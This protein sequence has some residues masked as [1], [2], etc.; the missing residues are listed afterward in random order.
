[1]SARNRILSR[2]RSTLASRTPVPHPG[3]FSGSPPIALRTAVAAFSEAFEKAGGEVVRV[4]DDDAA[5]SWLS[6]TGAHF[7]TATAG[8]GVPENLRPALPS[9]D[10]HHADLGVSMARYAVA[11]TGSLVLGAEDG[12][13]AQILPPN[14]IVFVRAA[15]VL[16]TLAEALDALRSELPSAVALH[17]GP[18]KSADIGQILVKGVHGPGR[19]IAVVIGDLGEER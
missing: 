5:A 6:E 13:R 14:H 19:V 1:M 8:A 2:I 7:R 16:G 10:P 9:S 4:T 17:S 3:R 11:E 18:S 12:R 15:D